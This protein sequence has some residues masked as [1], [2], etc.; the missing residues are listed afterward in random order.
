QGTFCDPYYGGNANFVGWDLLAYPGVRLAVTADEQR[1]LGVDLP[2]NH[3]S[4]Y[5][6]GAFEKQ[7]PSTGSPGPHHDR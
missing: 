3:R 7:P 5:D 6:Y 2:A 4:A 1:R